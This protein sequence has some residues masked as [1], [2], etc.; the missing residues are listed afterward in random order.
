[1]K[2]YTRFENTCVQPEKFTQGLCNLNPLLS[3]D[4]QLFFYPKFRIVISY[5]LQSSTSEQPASSVFSAP[6][7]SFPFSKFCYILCPARCPRVH[8]ALMPN[9]ELSQTEEQTKHKNYRQ[10]IHGCHLMN[11][12]R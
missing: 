5:P 2:F 10:E 9:K 12:V 4:I 11:K 1:M 8:H 7:F 3:V 6:P